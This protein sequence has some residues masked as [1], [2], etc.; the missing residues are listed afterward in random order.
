M[1]FLLVWLGVAGIAT[2]SHLRWS[3]ET[4]PHHGW[5]FT[6]YKNPKEKVHFKEAE[7]SG[8]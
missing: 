3:Q 2:S 5:N 4:W 6:P 1:K 7:G 8:H